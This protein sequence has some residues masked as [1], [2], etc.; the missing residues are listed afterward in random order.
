M[1][2]CSLNIRALNTSKALLEDYV[3]NNGIDL[4]AISETHNTGDT[5]KF[6]NWQTK[7]L[8][9]N[10][11][12]NTPY[13]GVALIPNPKLQI[14]PRRDLNDLANPDL[15]VVWAQIAHKNRP[16]T[17]ACA[18]ISP[19]SNLFNAFIDHIKAVLQ[20]LPPNSPILICGDINARSPLWENQLLHNPPDKQTG[21]IK[22]GKT[23]E[24]LV[25]SHNLTI[26]NNG[27]ITWRSGKLSSSPDVTLMSGC[28]PFKVEWTTDTRTA[29]AKLS[30]HVPIIIKID[31]NQGSLN[32]QAKLNF[33]KADWNSYNESLEEKTRS[34]M[35][36]DFLS[37]SSDEIVDTITQIISETAAECIP[38]K[39]TCSHSK[40]FFTPL[41]KEKLDNFKTAKNRFKK[42]SDPTNS[43]LKEEAAADFR[44][45]Y[46]EEKAKWLTKIC[47]ELKASDVDLWRKINKI[48]NGQNSAPV[49]PLQIGNTNEFDFDDKII[50]ERMESVHITRTNS[51]TSCFSEEFK[52]QIETE[53]DSFTEHLDAHPE[54]WNEEDFNQDL[55]EKEVRSSINKTKE[56]S[57]P[58]PDKVHPMMITRMSYFMITFLTN[59]FQTF[60]NRGEFPQPMKRGNVIYLQKPG[61]DTY[62]KEKSY[63]PICLTS[64][65]AKLYER[66]LAARLYAHLR[67]IG[68]FNDSQYAY[69]KG[70]DCTQAILDMC[71]DAMK[72]FSEKK[73]TAAAF[74]DLEGAFDAVWRKGLLHK[75]R[76]LG[77]KGRLYKAIESF[78]QSRMSRSFINSFTT[79]WN[80]T[81]VGVPQGSVLSALLFLVFTKDLTEG[82]NNNSRYADDLN[83]YE[84][85]ESPAVASKALEEDLI[86]I[87]S[88]CKNWRLNA[89]PA[90]TTCMLITNRGHVDI[91][92]HLN[93]SKITQVETQKVLGI[94][95][96]E[97]LRFKAHIDHSA[98]R[99]TSALN[100]IA[101]LSTSLGGAPSE[102]LLL[103]YKACVL[104]LL[105]YGY[106]VWCTGDIKPLETVQQ[107]ALTRILGAM[108]H[109]SGAAMEVLANVMPLAIR[110]Q[111][112]LVQAYLRIMR[113]PDNN[114]LKEKIRRLEIDPIMNRMWHRTTPLGMLMM[115]KHDLTDFQIEHIEPLIYE[116]MDQILQTNNITLVITKESIGSSG[117]RTPEQEKRAQELALAHVSEAGNDAVIF[118]DGSA[119]P[120]PGPC[121]AGLCAY[122]AGTAADS[123]EQAI[124]VAKLSTSYHGELKAIDKAIQMAAERGYTGTLHILSDCQSALQVAAA[125]ELPPNFTYLAHSIKQHAAKINGEIKLT[126]IAGHADIPGNEAADKQAK[127]GATQA[128]QELSEC[129]AIISMS[130]AKSRIK[131]NAVLK[132]KLRWARQQV[133]NSYLQTINTRRDL[134]SLYSREVETTVYRLIL[135]HNKLEENMHKI[136]PQAQP[137]PACVCN[138]GT[139]DTEHFMA[140]CK[141]FSAQRETMLNAIEES[142]HKHEV[143]ADK[144]SLSTF[145]LLGLDH[146]LPKLVQKDIAKALTTF[147]KTT[148]KPI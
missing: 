134:T 31:E 38:A 13:G 99:A 109:T 60:W 73:S 117:N 1:R 14:V 70:E 121:G 64:I 130:E 122:W 7:D 33:K 61:K 51:D 29:Y 103:L 145:T 140:E 6:K 95:I 108:E 25:N 59:T 120:N 23:I 115:A 100:K 82:I 88:W 87:A 139:G 42:R 80:E 54:T 35:E 97:N 53:V 15:E 93:G 47:E 113:K 57:A 43:K 52:Q 65:I 126:W 68:F 111:I 72:G 44:K 112:T 48:L 28:E 71:L 75:L 142:F 3:E 86:K 119:Q 17:I 147:I 94:I 62:S 40:P 104:P 81:K 24:N 129:D 146:T 92:V 78:L 2:I 106:P 89:N 20:I 118:T 39:T 131:T 133:T 8:F 46:E 128:A 124:P 135:G 74:I 12:D 22:R 49:Q 105:E 16:L 9:K 37:R 102:V 27:D 101:L 66:M 83:V 141:L 4:L 107:A 45:C 11:T 143:P 98:A 76:L 58:G 136:Y 18:Y 144:Q 41:L 116:S 50:A 127:L 34:L 19:K 132:W 79:E 56:D 96:D 77:V 84:T 137:S 85:D 90:K 36:N 26:L 69:Q 55:S 125:D 91:T 32:K 148:N 10:R 114:P 123:I 67:K 110:L 5:L 30:D 138:E 21:A 63:R